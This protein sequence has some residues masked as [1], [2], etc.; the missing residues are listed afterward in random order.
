MNSQC[1][2][3]E[4]PLPTEGEL[5]YATCSICSN[6]YHFECTTVGESSWRTMGDNRRG[7]WKCPTCRNPATADAKAGNTPQ[8]VK[9]GKE[10]SC[11]QKESA[12]QKELTKEEVINLESDVPLINQ[13]IE[14]MVALE[15]SLTQKIDGGFLNSSNDMKELKTKIAG[16]ETTLNFYGDKVDKAVITVKEFEHRM[17]LMERR[18]DKSESEN[19]ELKSKLRSMEIQVNGQNQKDYNTKIEISGIKDSEVDKDKVVKQILNKVEN[20]AEEIFFKSEKVTKKGENGK[21]S[22]VVEFRSRDIRNMVLTKIKEKRLYTQLDDV[23]P[24]NGSHVYI[25]EALSPYY[26]KLMYQASKIKRE[27][28]YAFLWVNDGKILLK[29]AEGSKIM[30]LD[31]MDDLGKI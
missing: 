27:K 24:N 8:P 17:I 23:F 11:K 31:C 9:D 12:K 19:K 15:N 4:Q 30:R 18:V 13:L 14:K 25:N 10:R 3:C 1:G 22:L 2:R 7:T 5:D 6:G 21:T 28:N 20:K 29:K 26:K 16:F